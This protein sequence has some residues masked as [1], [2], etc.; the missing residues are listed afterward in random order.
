MTQV[1]ETLGE[2]GT[3]AVMSAATEAFFRRSCG[4]ELAK[5]FPEKPGSVAEVVDLMDRRLGGKE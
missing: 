3:D 5:A 1:L 2:L 4:L